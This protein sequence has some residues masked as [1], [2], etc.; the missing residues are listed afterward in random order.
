VTKRCQRGAHQGMT[1]GGEEA[2]Q[3]LELSAST[4]ESGT[5]LGNEA[6]SSVVG[7]G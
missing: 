1:G 6:K 4:K 2:R 7:Q 3:R 5:E